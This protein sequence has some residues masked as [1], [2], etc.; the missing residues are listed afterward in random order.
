M[1]TMRNMRMTRVKLHI[2]IFYIYIY[3]YIYIYTTYIF[4]NDKDF[5]HFSSGI[6]ELRRA[7]LRI[8]QIFEKIID[9]DRFS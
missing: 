9:K 1:E 4:E 7:Y 6:T 3:I 5:Y 2:Y 8:I